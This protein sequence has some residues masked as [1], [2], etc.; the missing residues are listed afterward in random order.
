MS[1]WHFT[2]RRYIKPGY[3]PTEKKVVY[4]SQNITWAINEIKTH[5]ASKKQDKIGKS[6]SILGKSISLRNLIHFV[7]DM[8]Q[9]L[10]TT[11][12]VSE[13]YP[14][15]DFGGNAFYIKHYKNW[16]WNSLHFIWDHL[17]DLGGANSDMNS[18]LEDN[19]FDV[20]TNFAENIMEEYSYEDLKVQIE[21]NKTV[22]SW[23]DEGF[24][25]TS[26][27]VYKG[28]EERKELP[29]E[30]ITEGRKVVKKRLALAGY[31]LADLMVEIFREFSDGKKRKVV[32]Y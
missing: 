6:Q 22:E 23:N 8:H 2:D 7:G 14:N 11:G 10:H 24:Q 26:T 31:R 28:L 9:P 15:G 12:R 16:K 30:Y 18:P 25:I 32:V 13:K 19:E 3:Q 17:F 21:T 1:G 5:L 4:Q 27:F 29:E 20:L